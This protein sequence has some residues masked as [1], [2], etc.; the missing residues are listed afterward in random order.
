MD[1]FYSEMEL[2][3][4]GFKFLGTGVL[5]SKKASLYGISDISIGDHVRI[6]DFCILSGN[7]QIGSFVHI[8]AYTALFGGKTG[9]ILDD[10]SGISS[11]CVIYAESDDYSGEAMTNPMIPDKYRKVYG[12]GVKI[13]RHGIIGTGSTILPAVEIG[14]G[15]S[16][17]AM[18][19]VA[20]D[21]APWS[22]NVGIPCKKIKD[23]SKKLL[24]L[25][26][27]FMVSIK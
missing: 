4:L 23:R 25:E 13:G 9:I 2:T 18:S 21:V 19:L 12:N 8:S 16:I 14:E 6:D 24:T 20:K 5:I 15:A 11:R 10:F 3:K 7:I 26:K 27:E 1:S 22:I 17:G